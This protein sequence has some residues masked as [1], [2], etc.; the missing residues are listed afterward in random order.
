MEGAMQ[1][2]PQWAEEGEVQLHPPEGEVQMEE[3]A[4]SVDRPVIGQMPVPKD[5][6]AEYLLP[7]TAK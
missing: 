1:P 4:L 2:P 5:R 6:S 3:I 7:Y